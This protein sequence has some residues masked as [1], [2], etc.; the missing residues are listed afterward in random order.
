MA[1]EQFFMQQTSAV[2]HQNGRP[3][4]VWDLVGVYGPD[5]TGLCRAS[6]TILPGIAG[7]G[8]AAGTAGSGPPIRFASDETSS[9]IEEIQRTLDEGPC[10]DAASARQPVVAA[11]LTSGSW[12]QRWPRFTPAALDAGVRAVFALPLHAGG[13]RHDGAVDLYRRSPGGLDRTQR[14]TALAFASAAAELLTLEHL[15]LDLTDAF[16][17]SRDGN[18]PDRVEEIPAYDQSMTAPDE[19]AVLLAC[20]VDAVTLPAV[21]AQ[22]RAASADR[23][24]SGTGLYEFVLA[25]YEAL[26]NVLR[27]G[28]GRGQ[29]LL[30]QH[31]DDLWCEVTD[32]GPGISGGYLPARHP[33]TS[34]LGQRGLWI[35]RRVCTSC[36]VTTDATGTRMLLRYRIGRR[37]PG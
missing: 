29:L 17:L 8:L 36:K 23:G 26:T 2:E 35:I 7:V 28:G 15:D 13:V 33:G 21:R 31:A 32:H 6:A 34:Q 12:Q 24:L 10:R 11:D 3:A 4:A 9:Q 22:V 19:S 14:M 30:W 1:D 18:R 5:L 37:S 20:S 27:H 25:V 16:T